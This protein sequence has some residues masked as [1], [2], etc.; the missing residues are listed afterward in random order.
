[1]KRA[2]IYT[3]EKHVGVLAEDSEGYSFVSDSVI[4]D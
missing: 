4:D 2:R 3:G 1:M